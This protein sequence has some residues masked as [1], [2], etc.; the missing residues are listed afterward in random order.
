MS[1]RLS[2]LAALSSGAQRTRGRRP[3]RILR[4][5]G[6]LDGRRVQ[7]CP[8]AEL[9]SRAML[10]RI[11][12]RRSLA[13]QFSM[14]VAYALPDMAGASIA[15]RSCVRSN[16]VAVISRYKRAGGALWWPGVDVSELRHG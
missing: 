16:A 4:R 14:P 12:I 6:A 9:A 8:V 3:R 2:W 10:N 13:W 5:A 11:E 7:P 15:A 1:R